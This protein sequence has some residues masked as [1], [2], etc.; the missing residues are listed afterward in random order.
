[1]A[2]RAH[3]LIN[4][5]FQF[6]DNQ[7]GLRPSAEIFHFFENRSQRLLNCGQQGFLLNFYALSDAAAKLIKNGLLALKATQN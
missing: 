6:G 3:N 1:M 7:R 4:R 5:L 2:Q